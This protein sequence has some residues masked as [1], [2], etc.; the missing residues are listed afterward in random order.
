[1]AKNCP[2]EN[3]AKCLKENHQIRIW[4]YSKKSLEQ[5]L[6]FQFSSAIF[7]ASVDLKKNWDD[8]NEVIFLIKNGFLFRFNKMLE[9]WIY[10]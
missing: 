6:F 10:V 1:M 3:I 4:I 8:L 2:N 7:E 5:S 9:N